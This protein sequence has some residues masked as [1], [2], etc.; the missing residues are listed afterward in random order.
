MLYFLIPSRTNIYFVNMMIKLK[1]AIRPFDSFI[2]RSKGCKENTK[3][4]AKGLFNGKHLFLLSNYME[5]KFLRK[6][7][8]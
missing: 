5:A 8:H 3:Q 7:S 2:R 1:Q 6:G 4:K